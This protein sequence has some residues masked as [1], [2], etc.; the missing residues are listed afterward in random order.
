MKVHFGSGGNFYHFYLGYGSVLKKTNN[1]FFS[2]V[3]AGSITAG[4][5]AFDIPINTIYIP[6]YSEIHNKMKTTN[7]IL[8]LFMDTSYKYISKYNQ[9][10]PLEIHTSLVDFPYI[11]NHTF[12]E[13]KNTE[14]LI[15]KII[16]SCYIP[17][18]NN[19]IAYKYN[20]KWYIDGVL[21]Y[22]N[23]DYEK[24]VEYH[25]FIKEFSLFDK[26]PNKDFT[27]NI[28]LYN[29]GQQCCINDSTY[30]IQD[31]TPDSIH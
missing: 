24:K 19:N 9:R 27:K 28:Y 6:W 1:I 23:K 31:T 2:G 14:D 11:R 18:L 15:N 25:N 4:F 21:T 22:N 20:N 12:T 26:I 5:L 30:R 16:C 8:E 10:Y 17:L 3:S 7:K 29:L 13:F